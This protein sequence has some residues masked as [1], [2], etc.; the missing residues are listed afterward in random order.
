MDKFPNIAVLI[1]AAGA[2]KRIGMP[3][4]LLKWGPSN[5]LGHAIETAQKLEAGAIVVVLGAY[6]EKIESEIKKYDIQTLVNTSWELGLGSTIAVGLDHLI[7]NEKD[8]DAVLIM[9]PDQPLIVPYY[10]RC[11][12]QE[13]EPGQK[14]IIASR[15]A[16]GKFGVPALFDNHYFLELTLLQDDQGAKKLIAKHA[17]RVSSLDM[18]PLIADIDTLEDY[19]K[20]YDANHQ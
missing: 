20:M 19:N 12:M 6:F 3:K 16:E 8:F 9:L 1:P 10:L 17:Q 5:L 7:R 13:F 18:N 2:S 14:Q 15:Y 11:M 4:Q